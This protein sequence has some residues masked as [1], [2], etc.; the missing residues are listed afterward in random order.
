M[1]KRIFLSLL[2]C[3]AVVAGLQAE[4]KK[5]KHTHVKSGKAKSENVA[6]SAV[7]PK[8]LKVYMFG[9]AASFVDSVAYMTDLQPIDANV[10]ANGFLDAR[11]LYTLQFNNFLTVNKK[12]ENMTCAVFFNKDK[13]KAEK[14][15][16]KLRRRYRENE[17]IILTP[18][19]VDEF[20]F[21]PEEY[22]EPVVEEVTQPQKEGNQKETLQKGKKE[23]GKK[24]SKKDT[25]KK[26]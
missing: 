3:L 19:G 22:V 8:P 6:K 23:K 1:T 12:R 20:K 4:T 14:R 9:F 26:K 2:L 10:Y 17:A 5:A 13:A 21:K 18:V 25:P 24:P 7:K 15:F 16:Q 11:S